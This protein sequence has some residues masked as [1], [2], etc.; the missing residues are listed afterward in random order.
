LTIF[1]VAQAVAAFEGP[2]TLGAAAFAGFPQLEELTLMMMPLRAPGAQLLA[3]RRWPRLWKLSLRHS[4][5]R[6]ASDAALA[7]GHWP[8]L[9]VLNL[10]QIGPRSMRTPLSIE[11]VWRLAPTL[12]VLDR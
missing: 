10:R 5:V 12:R 4:H 9:E 8:A 7:R 6:V 1:T 3:S 2:S 11:D